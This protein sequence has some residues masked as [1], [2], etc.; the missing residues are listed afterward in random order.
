MYLI[1]FRNSLYNKALTN[2]GC[3]FLNLLTFLI[4]KMLNVY[5]VK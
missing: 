1:D 3:S 4:K 5:V 2:I